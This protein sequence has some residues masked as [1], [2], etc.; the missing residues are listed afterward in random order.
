M[1]RNGFLLLIVCVSVV[2]GLREDTISFPNPLPH[3]PV[4]VSESFDCLAREFVW[5]YAQQIQP[6]RANI[7]TVYDAL[8]L[9]TLCNSTIEKRVNVRDTVQNQKVLSVRTGQY[10]VD[11]NSGSDSNPGTLSD[12]FLTIQHAVNVAVSN[13]VIYLRA[14]IYY[15]KDTIFL[16]PENSGLTFAS[17][18]GEDAQINGGIPLTTKWAPYNVGKDA[19]I[20]VADLSGQGIQNITGLQLNGLR[21]TRA[22]FPNANPETD[23]FPVGWIPNA[24]NWIPPHTYPA[25]TTYTL[26]T[27]TRPTGVAF[28]QFTIATGGAC[29]VFDPPQS[30]WC[31][32]D[33]AGGGA[34]TYVVPGGLVFTNETFS[35]RVWKNP[36]GAIVHA[37]HPGHWESW[38]FEIDSYDPANHTIGWH[39]GGFQ[40]ARGSPSGGE[41]YVDGIFEELDAPNEF[42]YDATSQLLYY[43][44]NGTGVPPTDSVFVATNLKVL[45]NV[46]GTQQ[47]PVTGLTFYNITFQNSAYTYMDPHGVP[48]GG[49]W[50]LQRTG[51][52]FFEGTEQ[53]NVSDCLFIR[54]DGNA[55]F[56]SGYNRNATIQRNEFVWIGDSAMASWGTTIDN[57]VNGTDGNFP[58]YTS[59]LY[60]FVHENGVWT[61]QTSAW[62]Q[63]KTVQT[64]FEGNIFFNGPRAGININDGFGGGNELVSNLLFNQVRETYDHGPFNSWDREP[65]WTD[66]TNETGSFTQLYNEVHHNVFFCNYGSQACIDNDDGSTYFKNHN[67]FEIYGCHKDYFAGHNKYTYDTVLA[68]PTCWDRGCAFFTEFVPGYVDGIYNVS[69]FMDTDKP[70]LEFDGVSWSIDNVQPQQLP[71]MGNNNIYSTNNVSIKVNSNSYSLDTWQAKGFDKGTTSRPFPAY[72]DIIAMGKQVLQN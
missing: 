13:S 47:S 36:I 24:A 46:T 7:D 10:Y 23:L 37:F 45:F 26:P 33:C 2:C 71:I 51:A 65:F 11:A 32:S 72:E 30:Y 18:N 64:Y 50:S 28:Q 70:Y 58:R 59:V 43:Y 61:K 19:N 25:A 4:H 31:S 20:Y 42:F 1:G 3:R 52:L 5:Q 35:G 17:Y 63:A 12:P 16:G 22:R 66:I 44:Y 49:D 53:L 67:N 40:G 15:L 56:L 69:C 48:S 41:W 55:L 29:S 8:Q 21:C 39:F 6:F 34:S 27:P 38:M 68:F 14:G 9:S 60:N 54:L 57:L 62:M